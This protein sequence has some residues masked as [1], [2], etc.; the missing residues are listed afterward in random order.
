MYPQQTV[1]AVLSL[2]PARGALSLLLLAITPFGLD[3]ESD[4]SLATGLAMTV[5]LLLLA[6]PVWAWTLGGFLRDVLV[7]R[8]GDD[9]VL[10]ALRPR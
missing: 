5:G 7:P 2:P 10:I 3:P 1:M 4:L 9:T 8:R 6:A